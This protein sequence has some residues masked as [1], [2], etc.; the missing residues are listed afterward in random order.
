M[1]YTIGNAIAHV[2]FENGSVFHW[3]VGRSTRL[4]TILFQD[5]GVSAAAYRFTLPAYGP[6]A[7]NS[8]LAS[9][10]AHTSIKERLM[11][12]RLISLVII[13]LH[14]LLLTFVLRLPVAARA[15]RQA[16]PPS[17]TPVVAP[18]Q[19]RVQQQVPLTIVV[20]ATPTTDTVGVTQTV[21]VTLALQVDFVLTDT[22]TATLPASVIF[23]FAE[24]PTTTGPI[25]F[26][27]ALT[28]TASLVLTPL[29]PITVTPLISATELTATTGTPITATLL[30]TTPAAIATTVAITAN[31]RSGPDTTFD[32]R[33]TFVPGEPVSVVARNNDSTWYLLDNGLWV[34]AFLLSEQPTDLPIAT[35]EL[36]TT[37][38]AL[39]PLTVPSP[40]IATTPLTATGALTETTTPVTATIPTTTTTAG[41]PT[42]RPTPTPATTA[43]TATTPVTTSAPVTTTAAP[44]R[45][46]LD[47]NLR[48]GPGTTFPV[49]GGT[50]TGQALTIVARN[51]DGSW[52]RLDNGGWVA[53]FLVANAPDPATVPLFDEN[54]PAPTPTATTPLTPTTPL[55]STAP[56]S[57]TFGVRENLYAIR[58]DGIADRY[59]FALTQIE[60]L[61]TQAQA[62]TALLENQQWIIQMTTMITLLRSAGDE[63]QGL[64]PPDLFAGAHT[65]LLT[66]ATA[67]TAAADLLAEGIDQL[68]A[69]ILAEAT[70]QINAG[71]IAL[72]A[73]QTAIERLSP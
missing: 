45:V 11:K 32:V 63:L 39:N 26:L 21:A 22:L 42:L 38:R 72:G 23:R 37:L 4:G 67:Y 17:T 49:V 16:T 6:A 28:P 3:Y 55:T 70:A 60:G 56:V 61:V 29:A 9:S 5:N 48:E 54:A 2:L 40:L 73:A 66:A 19:L 34:A 44:P 10:S 41:L 35:E 36:A 50:V 25:S 62:D 12:R 18:L 59:D 43:V 65:D 1:R 20:P 15:S 30:T 68:Q 14:L 71:N 8:D 31:I 46:T 57:P 33:A 24:Q 27:V 47:A 53:A 58:V 7:I 64:A 52:F 13:G 69:D 51:A